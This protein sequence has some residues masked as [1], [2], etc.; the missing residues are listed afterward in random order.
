MSDDD[1]AYEETI[2]PL[3]SN[4]H[5]LHEMYLAFMQ[6]GFSE[7]RAFDLVNTVLMDHLAS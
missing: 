3:A 5:E 1:E 2:T 4:A 7:P 6:A